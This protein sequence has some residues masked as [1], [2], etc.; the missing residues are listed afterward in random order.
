MAATATA[1]DLLADLAADTAGLMGPRDRDGYAD[2]AV[3]TFK[4]IGSPGFPM[5][6]ERYSL[7]QRQRSA[8]EQGRLEGDDPQRHRAGPERQADRIRILHAGLTPDP[9]A[10]R[11]PAP[12]HTKIA[13]RSPNGWSNIR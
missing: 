6:E 12:G 11:A 4:V 5:D 3:R 10:T 9:S 13:I 1:P 2:Q 8:A 7:G